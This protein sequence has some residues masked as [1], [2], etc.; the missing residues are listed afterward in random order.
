M[1]SRSTEG[2]SL[3]SNDKPPGG[4]PEQPPSQGG[5]PGQYGGQG[6]YGGQGQYGGQQ[7]GQGQ[8]GGYGQQSSGS[9][10]SPDETVP[11]GVRPSG[12][13]HP[14]QQPSGYEETVARGVQQPG[15]QHDQQQSGWQQDQQQ[16]GWPQDQQQ[17]SWQPNQQQPSGRSRPPRRRHRG[18]R[19]LIALVVLI[20][21]LVAADF[22]AKALAENAIAAKIQSSG[23]GTKPSV[24]I[25][26][27]PFLTQVASRDLS[28]IDINASNFT[29]KQVVIS[30][31]HATA[32]GVHVNG[33]FNGGTVDKING[34][35]V[36]SF[37]TVTN[38]IPIP[39]LT[40]TA[41][42]ADG[43]DAIKFDSSLG[44]AT[45]KIEHP[46]ANVIKVDVG[47]LTG[48]AGLASLI[49]GGSALQSSY[50]FD[51]PKLPAGLV[52]QSISVTSQGIVA[53]ASA[54][55]TTLSQ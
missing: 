50:T 8:P 44:G 13:Q 19:W 28:Q 9:S 52:V 7:G 41:D 27:F 5:Q 49:G 1:V 33:S 38:L 31:L 43:Q 29:V 21:I 12:W 18:R 46:S 51:I 30:S 55:N 14:Q 4:W 6:G 45:G 32:T 24:D 39:G 23:L 35:V 36:V 40:V 53:T 25:E 11:R 54:Q 37:A 34:T 47:N 48:L 17:P 2:S 42:P 20:V 3:V 26:G 16:P 15:W 22:G 10:G